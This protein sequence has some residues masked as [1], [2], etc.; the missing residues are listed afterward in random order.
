MF[1]AYTVELPPPPPMM[2]LQLPNQQRKS[3]CSGIT[4]HLPYLLLS[5]QIPNSPIM[6]PSLPSMKPSLPSPN[7][8]HNFPRLTNLTSLEPINITISPSPTMSALITL[9]IA[10]SLTRSLS[11]KHNIIPHRLKSLQLPLPLLLLSCFTPKNHC[12]STFHT[13]Q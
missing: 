7:H 3:T 10:S 6:S 12:F 5:T 13:S 9:D 8:S 2:L 11:N 4:S 1:A